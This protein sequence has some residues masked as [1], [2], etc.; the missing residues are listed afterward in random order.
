MKD[1]VKS[2]Q[3]KRDRS[4]LDD[5]F[6]FVLRLH[7]QAISK[8]LFLGVSHLVI[9]TGLA[10]AQTNIIVSNPPGVSTSFTLN[11]ANYSGSF[12]FNIV[13][14]IDNTGSIQNLQTPASNDLYQFYSNPQ[15][16]NPPS[17]NVQNPPVYVPTGLTWAITGN[18]GST[19][20]QPIIQLL[21]T[22]AS[23]TAYNYNAASDTYSNG[24][25]GN[26]GSNLV[27][28]ATNQ[29]ASINFTQSPLVASAY[30]VT[31]TGGSGSSAFIKGSDWNIN[32]PTYSTFGAAGGNVNF[33]LSN[34][35]GSAT[36]LFVSVSGT[37]PTGPT[38]PWLIQT[39]GIIASS[40][41]GA[42]SA[43]SFNNGHTITQVIG[44]AGNGGNV[45]VT[46][47]SGIEIALGTSQSPLTTSITSPVAGIV[48]T[49]IGGAAGVCC[50]NNGPVTLA[51]TG[52]W[53][54]VLQF[55]YNAGAGAV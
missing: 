45:N 13:G 41:G 32:I 47:G 55:P 38:F 54:S 14:G 35:T 29:A 50:S 11:G 28:N 49:S 7:R 39:G 37:S 26:Y 53:P 34:T 30:T 43:Y 5:S 20:N 22:G 24:Y 51:S 33:N 21:S 48:A 4:V 36:P 15:T 40:V 9:F 19:G 52:P 12:G 8:A 46:V 27:L 44:Q 17:G 42:G 3:Q 25:F 1:I 16:T 18:G 23:T 6:R 31:S 10:A 2:A